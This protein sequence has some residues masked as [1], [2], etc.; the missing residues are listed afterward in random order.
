MRSVHSGKIFTD[1]SPSLDFSAIA[2][3]AGGFGARA[4]TA[5]EFKHALANGIARVRTGQWGLIDARLGI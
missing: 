3:A 2:V 5:A 4:E 1:L